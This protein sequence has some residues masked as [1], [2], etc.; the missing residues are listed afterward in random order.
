[1]TD[2]DKKDKWVV[3]DCEAD[4]FVPSKFHCLSWRDQDD[5]KGTITEYS[6]I[7]NFFRRYSMYVGHN[8][9]RWDLPQLR[10]VVG[11]E[12]EDFQSIVDTL[13][14]AW[15]LDPDRPRHNLESYGE[16]FE[17]EKP[18]VDDWESQDL[19]VYK[20]RCERDVE[21][22]FRLWK[23]Q[24]RRLLKLYSDEDLKRFLKYIDFK[25]YSAHLA[26]ESRWKLDVDAVKNSIQ[27]LTEERDQKLETLRAS[28][29]R[30][31]IKSTYNPPKR[32]YRADGELSVLGQRWKDRLIEGGFPPEH[33][34]P[35][36]V[37][38]GYD[39]PNPQSTD[40]VK[41]WLFSLGW[42]PRTIKYDRNKKTGEVREIPQVNL[43]NG[44]G[45]CESV[46]ELYEKEPALEALDSLGVIKHRLGLLNGYLRDV[47]SDGYLQACVAGLTNTLRFKHA[48][49][50]NLPKVEKP[51]GKDIRGPLIAPEG[52][53]LCGSDM[54]S[55]EDRI[56]QHFIYPFDPEYV[57]TMMSD[58]FDP[59]LDLALLA[60]ALTKE[61]VRSYHE[62]KKESVLYV[63]PIRS[64][65]KN[66]NYACQYG[67]GVSRLA[68]TCACDEET[69]RRVHE[70]YWKRN[71][72][73][74]AVAEKQKTK[75][76]D[77]QMWLLNP[78]SKFWYS[79]RTKKD[80]F[81][82]LVQGTAA[83]VFDTWLAFVLKERPQVTGQFHDEF[84]LCVRK[85][86]REEVERFLR[87]SIQKVND[88]LKLNRELDISVQFGDCY[89]DIH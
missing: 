84:I 7:R 3:F 55:L 57:K 46:Q 27:K 2:N 38:T 22:N 34:G 18:K 81:S 74:K 29:P 68:I 45:I 89:A 25:M 75:S 32:R 41:D 21:I 42:R 26:E 39:E 12:W 79:L 69:A 83:F 31:P 78:I 71:W 65:Y 10:R 76:V 36:D 37:I 62:G 1:V 17:V 50:V 14:L 67:A 49:I 66:G 28:M 85:G 86:H 20:F 33:D 73:I 61:D 5:D 16:D 23:D 6:E 59:H 13:G 60:G 80:V 8:I 77:G 52:M 72:A 82:T 53:E 48:E 56:K 30:V 15:Y 64:I 87:Q 24:T 40:Q 63:K 88:Y 35:I 54:S 47:S 19:S 4:G 11:I 58:D 9:R 51:Y 70:T 44:G 43:P